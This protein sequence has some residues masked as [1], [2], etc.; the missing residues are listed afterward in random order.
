[1]KITWLTTGSTKYFMVANFCC[2]CF[3][4]FERIAGYSHQQLYQAY[5]VHGKQKR[6]FL[7][8]LCQ[9]NILENQWKISCGYLLF[10]AD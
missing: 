1:M 3:S 6:L 10:N 5:K 7:Q 4:V 2:L 9:A 8:V